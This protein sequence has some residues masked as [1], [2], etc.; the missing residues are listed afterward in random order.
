MEDILSAIDRRLI[1]EMELSVPEEIV[2]KGRRGMISVLSEKPTRIL[3][4]D[5]SGRCDLNAE[6]RP[7]KF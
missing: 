2:D 3:P 1:V 4:G 5:L 7:S 6:L